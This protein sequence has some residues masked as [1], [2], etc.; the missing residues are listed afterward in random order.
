M[1]TIKKGMCVK[2][3]V[4]NGIVERIDKTT[5][6][7]PLFVINITNGKNKGEKVAMVESQLIKSK[8]CKIKK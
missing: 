1:E 4:G 6:S 5:Y 2:T 7:I 3:K 8:G